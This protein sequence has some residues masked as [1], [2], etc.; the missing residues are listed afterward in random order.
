MLIFAMILLFSVIHANTPGV[1][2]FKGKFKK[3]MTIIE[4]SVHKIRQIKLTACGRHVALAV[5]VKFH[6][7][8]Q[9]L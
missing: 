9:P 8:P 7:Y 2:L 4:D 3:K 5:D 1:C 6:V